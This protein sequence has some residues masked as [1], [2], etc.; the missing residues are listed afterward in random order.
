M[1]ETKEFCYG[2]SDGNRDK[3]ALR[4][5]VK[6]TTDKDGDEEYKATYSLSSNGV[7]VTIAHEDVYLCL[8]CE[9]DRNDVLQK[10]LMHYQSSVMHLTVNMITEELELG[11]STHKYHAYKKKEE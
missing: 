3:W 9:P 4:A 6:M 5:L 11:D 1:N 10:C 7:D 8:N 2:Y